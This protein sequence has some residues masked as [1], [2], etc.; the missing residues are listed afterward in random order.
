MVMSI[1]QNPYTPQGPTSP[2][3][4][5]P[6]TPGQGG[7]VPPQPPAK[8]LN[9]LGIVALAIAA[10][11]LILSC[12]PGI[13]VVGWVL[14]PIG[15]ILG[16]VSLFLK[17]K[18]KGFGIGAIITSVV[19]TIVAVIVF[20]LMVA[21]AVNTAVNESSPTAVPPAQQTRP[22]DDATGPAED[23]DS[24]DE[25]SSDE[26]TR[27]NPFP[28]GTTLSNDEWEVTVNSVDLDATKKVA[29]ANRYNPKPEAGQIYIMANV[30]AKYIGEDESSSVLVTVEYVTPTGEVV[31][32]T[33]AV[34]LTENFEIKD[35]FTGGTVTGNM[36][37]LVPAE[38]VGEGVLRVSAGFGSGE[39]FV[40]VK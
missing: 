34:G 10:L 12:I 20:F 7:F 39:A 29:D 28:L 21:M 13:M 33:H 26:G 19:G 40:A 3:P 31:R 35:L 30:T 6:N 4:G 32:R 15:F 22:T 38:N 23:P 27:E 14:L 5:A 2:P 9:V 16:I 17:D 8:T 37:F 11:G 25:G 1:P 24:S 18:G 36:L